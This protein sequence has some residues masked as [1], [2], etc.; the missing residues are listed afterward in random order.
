MLAIVT[1]T[2]CL[3]FILGLGPAYSQ[4]AK[5][6]KHLDQMQALGNEPL[7]LSIDLRDKRNNGRPQTPLSNFPQ[8]KNPL[9]QELIDHPQ[10]LSSPQGQ[11]N[12]F[13]GKFPGNTYQKNEQETSLTVPKPVAPQPGRDSFKSAASPGTLLGGYGKSNET[14]GPLT[15]SPLSTILQ[16]N[17]LETSL[18]KPLY[19]KFGG[20]GKSNE[21]PGPL[22]FS[23]LSTNLQTNNLETSLQKSLYSKFGGAGQ[24]NETPGP[25]TFSPLSTNL[26][27]NNLETS[28]QR[29]LQ[30]GSGVSRHRET[31]TQ[32]SLRFGYASKRK[33]VKAEKDDQP[34]SKKTRN[35]PENSRSGLHVKLHKNY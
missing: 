6:E 5:P 14:P 9:T 2:L 21:T 35:K 4:T 26:Q 19:S 33:P 34:T 15:F 27:T 23:P 24:S 16:T 3:G 25:L 12:N 13:S 30:S 8:S 10:G 20:S 17:N 11:G 29:S 32:R 7:D 28:L 31:S 18:Q 22:T 1:L